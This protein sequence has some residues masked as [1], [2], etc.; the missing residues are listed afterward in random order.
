ML[1]HDR[2]ANRLDSLGGFWE[3]G[4]QLNGRQGG[5]MAESHEI[6]DED[7]WCDEVLTVLSEMESVKVEDG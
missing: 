2:T 4:M 1:V 3:A 6:F 7:Q 5:A